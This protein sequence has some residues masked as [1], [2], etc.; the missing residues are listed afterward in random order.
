MP[1]VHYD[2]LT[3]PLEGA[4]RRWRAALWKLVPAHTA[5]GRESRDSL[6]SRARGLE[7]GVGTGGSFPHYPAALII[8]TDVSPAN[9][10][11]A[12]QKLFGGAAESS[13]ACVL[14]VVADVSSLPFRDATFDWGAEALVF[15]EV[16][17]PV[18]GLR[19]VSRVLRDGAP[20]LMLEHVR[21]GGVLG[22]IAAA[23][24]RVTAPVWGEHFD[25]DTIT[26]VRDAGLR[27]STTAWLW[28]DAVLLLE[29][30]SPKALG[31][32][33]T[34]DLRAQLSDGE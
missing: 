4:L 28:R 2:I 16:R 5:S 18:E 24:T 1:L 14:L 27:I 12:K 8:A 9:M 21:P 34:S 32:V 31:E 25:R 26:A 23:V 7:I 20:F 17:D 15:C 3:R 11:T 6:R 10:V 33:P 29:V 22:A 13:G 30:L 19:E